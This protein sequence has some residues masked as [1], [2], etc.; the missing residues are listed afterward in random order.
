MSDPK[1]YPITTYDQP[2]S[3]PGKPDNSRFT[4]GDTSITSGP[5]LDPTIN[6]T[7]FISVQQGNEKASWTYTP[8]DDE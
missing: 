1:Q 3:D 4:I 8:D 7:N 6:D 5:S 2:G